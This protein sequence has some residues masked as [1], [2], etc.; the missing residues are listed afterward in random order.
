MQEH[1]GY[2][3]E[4]KMLRVHGFVMAAM[5]VVS[6]STTTQA[7]HYTFAAS[8]NPSNEVAKG[9]RGKSDKTN[10]TDSRQG[11]AVPSALET[12]EWLNRHLSFLGGT[13]RDSSE[14]GLKGEQTCAT[15]RRTLRLELMDDVLVIREERTTND[16]GTID[17]DIELTMARWDYRR[18]ITSTV[19]IRLPD[20]TAPQNFE[21][22]LPYK[23]KWTSLG[24]GSRVLRLRCRDGLKCVHVEEDQTVVGD[25]SSRSRSERRRFRSA[26]ELSLSPST[27]TKRRVGDQDTFAFYITKPE[28]ASEDDVNQVLKAMAHLV[29]LHG[30]GKPSIRF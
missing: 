16:K 3:K 8:V 9:V 17:A 18:T 7:Q 2:V 22:A 21:A 12:V 1:V 6:I 15:T 30:G 27:R 26:S 20:L 23:C 13:F 24:E 29:R 5:L 28:V 4:D 25:E 10:I 11:T 19:T 14:A